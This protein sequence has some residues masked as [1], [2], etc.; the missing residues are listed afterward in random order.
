MR[1][2]RPIFGFGGK[3]GNL[4]KMAFGKAIWGRWHFREIV[5]WK[6]DILAIYQAGEMVLGRE[7]CF[8]SG[9]LA[10]RDS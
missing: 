5:F 4:G 10:L 6:A 9:S 7:T 8:K 3:K 2:E 1:A